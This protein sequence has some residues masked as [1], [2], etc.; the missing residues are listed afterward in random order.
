MMNWETLWPLLAAMGIVLGFVPVAGL[1][2]TFVER[3][4]AALIQDRVGP[5]RVGPAGLFQAIADGIKIFLKEQ[6]IPAHVFKSVYFFAPTIGLICAMLSIAVVP[7]GPAPSSPSEGF[8]AIIAPGI[9]IG[10]LFLLAV[11]GLS[12]YGIILGGWASNNKYSLYGAIRSC[13]QFISYEIPL[14]LSLLGVIA[15]AG[16]LNIE[17]IVEA[18]GDGIA[19]WNVWWQPLAALLFFT[20]ALAETNRLPFDLPE[21]EQELVGGFHTE[22]SGIKFVLFFLAE[23]THVVTV[24]FLT[25]L[26]FFGGWHFPGLTGDVQ[27]SLAGYLIRWGVLIAKVSIVIAIIMQLRWTLPRFRFDQL[28]GLAWKGLIPLG[29]INLL[30]ILFVLMLDGSRW[31]LSGFSIVVLILAAALNAAMIQARLNKR[32]SRAMNDAV[33]SE[34]HAG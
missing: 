31:W 33:L 17:R 5:N 25:V 14:G 34:G 29:L 18:Q 32:S 6:V 8:R 11:S 30:G 10:L 21:C 12:T 3:K 4:L 27:S 28:M 24:S 13:A 7:F 26:F 15:V 20:A 1:Y 19:N 16:S 22:Y 2:M 9:D 23:Y